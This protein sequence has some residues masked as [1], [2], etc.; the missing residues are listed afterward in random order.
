MFWYAVSLFF[1]FQAEDGIRDIGV[2][3]VQTCALPICPTVVHAPARPVPNEPL[4]PGVAIAQIAAVVGYQPLGVAQV[5]QGKV[6]RR[7]RTLAVV[8]MGLRLRLPSGRSLQV[9]QEAIQ[10]LAVAALYGG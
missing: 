10:R 9:G 5:R 2:T 8:G 6:S 1:F 4:P 7:G 3:G